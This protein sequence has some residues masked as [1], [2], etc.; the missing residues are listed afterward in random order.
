MLYNTD[1]TVMTGTQPI[2]KR[3]LTEVTGT[4]IS[5]NGKWNLRVGDELLSLDVEALA[6]DNWPLSPDMNGL[7]ATV[8]VIDYRVVKIISTT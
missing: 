1:P 4:L 7:D 5:K 3:S 6:Q 2:R 8:Q